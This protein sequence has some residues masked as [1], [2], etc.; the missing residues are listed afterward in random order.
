MPF[1]D[2]PTRGDD[3]LDLAITHVENISILCP[4][5]TIISR[6]ITII[7]NLKTSVEYRR[8]TL[9]EENVQQA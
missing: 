7:F 8:E 9:K 2:H 6:T 5:D 4:A 1:F 3:V